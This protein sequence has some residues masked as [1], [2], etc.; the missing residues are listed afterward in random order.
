MTSP[1]Q[2]GQFQPN[3][4]TLWKVVNRKF[5]QEEIMATDSA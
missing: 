1:Q 4:I 5:A 3:G 2:T